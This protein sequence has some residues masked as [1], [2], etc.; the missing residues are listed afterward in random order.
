[1][2]PAWL[3]ARILRLSRRLKG[4]TRSSSCDALAKLASYR[5]RRHE[6][7]PIGVLELA[8][9]DRR[10]LQ[11]AA[12]TPRVRESWRRVRFL[13]EQA[14]AFVAAGGGGLSEFADWVDE[15]LAEGLRAVESVLPEPDED[16]VHILTVH[17]AKGL[18]FPI[19]VLAG[20]GTTDAVSAP[21]VPAS[22]GTAPGRRCVSGSAS[23]RPA[24]GAS[25]PPS[26]RKT[27]RRPSG[28]STWR[29]RED[30]IT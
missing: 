2:L 11:L 10:L 12:T 5:A 3:L 27:G 13:L 9:R 15:Q 26:R 23:R 6:L 4:V 20:F 29:R 30:G 21:P 16:V 25:T 14:R 7:G 19:T 1:M 28:S 22:S 8:V 18:E 17:G 24:T